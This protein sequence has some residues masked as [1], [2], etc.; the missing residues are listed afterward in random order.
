MSDSL[1]R[2]IKEV[3]LFIIAAGAHETQRE[4]HHKQKE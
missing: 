1:T 3:I 4:S 2:F